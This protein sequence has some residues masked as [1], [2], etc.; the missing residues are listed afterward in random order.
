MNT[1]QKDKDIARLAIRFDYILI[2]EYL[3]P[4]ERKTGTELFAA[5]NSYAPE[6]VE[7]KQCIT[8]SDFISALEDA[9]LKI[10][11]KGIPVIHIESHGSSWD[12]E[13]K[14]AYIGYGK[15]ERICF[16][17]IFSLL[18]D[19]NIETNFNIILSGAS[20]YGAEY[21]RGIARNSESSILASLPFVATV[22]FD[23][24]VTDTSVLVFYSAFYKDI[25]LQKKPLLAATKDSNIL[26]EEIAILKFSALEIENQMMSIPIDDEI[27][28]ILRKLNITDEIKRAQEE[29]R[30]R[31]II[32]HSI[33]IMISDLFSHKLLP[34]NKNRFSI[35]LP[36]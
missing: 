25:I 22:G 11:T 15:S 3:S 6:S 33:E 30:I 2:I 8:K 1:P 24:V 12:R 35:K 16:N 32:I 23:D 27:Q 20:C 29:I 28:N 21:L 4:Y 36:S 13:N 18:R 26:I 19:L 5:I 7:L 9:R 31:E 14:N 34:N 10:K 17:E